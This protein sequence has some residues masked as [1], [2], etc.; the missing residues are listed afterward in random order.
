VAAHSFEGRL[1]VGEV[2]RYVGA[3]YGIYDGVSV[4]A[5]TDERGRERTWMLY[6]NEPLEVWPR[7]FAAVTN[8]E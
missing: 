2:L 4:Y 7:V 6:D 1:G 3:Y 5:F 8:A